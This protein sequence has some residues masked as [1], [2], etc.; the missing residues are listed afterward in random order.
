MEARQLLGLTKRAI[1]NTEMKTLERRCKKCKQIFRF[2]YTPGRKPSYCRECRSD[3][4]VEMM[5]RDISWYKD[6]YDRNNR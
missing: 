5:M 4:Y 6:K 3:R 2:E 1:G